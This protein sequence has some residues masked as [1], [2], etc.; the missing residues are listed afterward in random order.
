MSRIIAVV[1]GQTPR[2]G[3][4]FR[5]DLL[6]GDRQRPTTPS[7][8]GARNRKRREP[9]GEELEFKKYTKARRNW[10]LCVPASLKAKVLKFWH[11]DHGHPGQYKSS[12]MLRS[13]MY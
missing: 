7:R 11:D 12:K 10:V 9:D 4:E 13:L 1:R 2:L 6:A 3:Y 5:R 8:Y